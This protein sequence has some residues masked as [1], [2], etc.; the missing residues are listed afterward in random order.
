[1]TAFVKGEHFRGNI[2]RGNMAPD[3]ERHFFFATANV[4]QSSFLSET[5]SDLRI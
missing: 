3:A 2:R 5:L 1:M 4:A